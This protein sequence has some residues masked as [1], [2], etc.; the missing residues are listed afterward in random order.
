MQTKAFRIFEMA[1]IS[2]IFSD[3]HY[4]MILASQ[5]SKSEVEIFGTLYV[6]IL[7]KSH[8]RPLQEYVQFNRTLIS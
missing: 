8:C 4:Y 5:F 1:K 7:T 3:I 2:H 6:E